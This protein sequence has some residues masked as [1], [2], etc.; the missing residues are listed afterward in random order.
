MGQGRSAFGRNDVR[1]F[2]SECRRK[3]DV[4]AFMGEEPAAPEAVALDGG[5]GRGG[6]VCKATVRVHVPLS[7]IMMTETR[8]PRTTPP[9]RK[10]AR[11]PARRNLE[12]DVPRRMDLRQ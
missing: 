7:L 2:H 11:P 9:V 12:P 4:G 6:E 8:E 10:I 3:L 5:V 1:G